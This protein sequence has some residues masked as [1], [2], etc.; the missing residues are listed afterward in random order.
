M[1]QSLSNW[2]GQNVNPT[3]AMLSAQGAEGIKGP[4]SRFGYACRLVCSEC[5]PPTIE[6]FIFTA[7]LIF[8][9]PP[10]IVRSQTEEINFQGSGAHLGRV[11]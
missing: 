2:E 8:C 6:A 10:Q 3:L 5:A 9:F 7:L 1:P 11:F 4:V